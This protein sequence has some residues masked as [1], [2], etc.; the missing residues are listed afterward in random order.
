MTIPT[1]TPKTV[2]RVIGA[3]IFI[4][5]VSYITAMAV[6]FVHAIP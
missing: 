6:A 3:A 2:L 4:M 1:P 5:T